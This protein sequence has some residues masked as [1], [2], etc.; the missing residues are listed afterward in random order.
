MKVFFDIITNHTADV[1]DYAEGQYGY[2]TK[3]DLPLHRRRRHRLR[4][5]DF[6]GTRDFPAL[7]ATTSFPYTPVF[8]TPADATV[9]VPAWLN[10]PTIY[11]NRG[12]S[13]FAGESTDLRRLLRPRRP[14]HRAARRSSTGMEDI[15]KAW[16]DFGIDGFRID[17]V[18]HV[19]M[20]FWQSFTPGDAG[21]RPRHR[22]RR[23]LHVRRGL[24]RLA[25]LQSQYS[26][27]GKLPATLDFGFQAQPV[28]CAQ[29]KPRH[30]PARPLRRRRLLHRHRLQRLRAAD[31][32]RQPRH[33]PGRHDAQGRELPTTPTCCGASSS[34]TR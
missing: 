6:A 19:N 28:S 26:T 27:T 21:R 15:Y 10:D 12:D 4:R 13:T 14:L 2:V 32:P 24:R 5:R 34:P 7:D 25:G 16:V 9:K 1:V 20:E 3:A 23:L 22:Q 17:T 30:R 8:R 31:L 18:K 29:G 11:H 33:G